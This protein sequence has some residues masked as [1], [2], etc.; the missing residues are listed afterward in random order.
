MHSAYSASFAI[1][2]S[3]FEKHIEVISAAVT[4]LQ[5]KRIV[6]II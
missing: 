3:E 1:L 6:N 2:G 5:C 4:I